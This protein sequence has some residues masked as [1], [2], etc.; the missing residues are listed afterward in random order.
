M[1]TTQITIE[2][3]RFLLT[4]SVMGFGS[5]VMLE[6]RLE[7][8]INDLMLR[9]GFAEKVWSA[10]ENTLDAAETKLYDYIR[11]DF[12]RWPKLL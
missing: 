10:V 11:E 3:E 1:I 12:N 2:G 9:R 8:P 7:R 5:Y 6:A 4:F